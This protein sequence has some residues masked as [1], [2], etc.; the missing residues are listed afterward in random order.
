MVTNLF[1]A[2]NKK[3]DKKILTLLYNI[4]Y[5]HNFKNRSKIYIQHTTLLKD[6]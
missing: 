1:T 6:N 2:D 4:I 3:A 5:V